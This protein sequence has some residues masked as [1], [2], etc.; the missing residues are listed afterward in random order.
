MKSCNLVED[1]GVVNYIFTDKT[2]TLTVNQ[3]NFKALSLN[4][5]VFSCPP[6]E[7]HDDSVLKS[8]R[9]NEILFEASLA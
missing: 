6:N 8:D 4:S 7:M 9:L 1:L 3:M 5:R 2:G